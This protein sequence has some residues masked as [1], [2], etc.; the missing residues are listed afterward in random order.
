MT[1]RNRASEPTRMALFY[2]CELDE[3]FADPVN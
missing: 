2:V 1:D 3:P